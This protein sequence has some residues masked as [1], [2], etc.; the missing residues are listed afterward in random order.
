MFVQV[1]ERRNHEVI[2]GLT[3]DELVKPDVASHLAAAD[4][5]R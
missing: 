3:W 4:A 1:S 2:C 5:E